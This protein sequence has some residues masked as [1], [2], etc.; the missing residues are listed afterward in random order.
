MDYSDLAFTQGVDH[1]GVSAY[2][3]K[4]PLSDLIAAEEPEDLAEDEREAWMEHR[5]NA[6]RA[7]IHAVIDGSI[8]PLHIGLNFMT[9]AWHLQIAPF[10]KMTLEQIGEM[11]GLGRA[12]VCERH[13]KQVQRKL[14]AVGQKGVRNSRQKT[15]EVVERCRAGAMGNKNRRLSAAKKKIT[16][17]AKKF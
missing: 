14:E 16:R 3:V 10:D 11:A 5:V 17:L 2:T 6:L 13:K 15:A 8:N 9:W 7:I 4:T 12:A 1:R